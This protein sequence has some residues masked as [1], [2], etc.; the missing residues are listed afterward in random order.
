MIMLV[1]WF[2]YCK[3]KKQ[4]LFFKFC[5]FFFSAEIEVTVDFLIEIDKLVQLIESPIFTCEKNPIQSLDS[6]QDLSLFKIFV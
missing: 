4:L 2:N 6:I 5:S 1:H 3:F